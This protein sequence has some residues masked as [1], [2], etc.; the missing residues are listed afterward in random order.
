M[1]VYMYIKAVNDSSNVSAKPFFSVIYNKKKKKKKEEERKWKKKKK[2]KKKIVKFRRQTN[3]TMLVELS[4]PSLF[5]VRA[6][7][8]SIM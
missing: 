5:D 2:K 7:F 3:A 1:Y 8:R 4:F 6:H